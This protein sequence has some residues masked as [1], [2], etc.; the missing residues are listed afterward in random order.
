MLLEEFLKPLGVSPSEFAI[1]LG[2]PFA[3]LNDILRGKRG[4]TPD[5]ALR[6]ARLLGISA[7]FWSD[8]SSTGTCGTP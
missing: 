7:D 2:V 8:C 1:K 6:L 4:P 5:T 3:R